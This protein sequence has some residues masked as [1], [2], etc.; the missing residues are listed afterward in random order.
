MTLYCKQITYDEILPYWDILWR[1]RERMIQYSAMRM[2]GGYD[3]DIKNTYKWRAFAVCDDKRGGK[4]V[5]VNAGHKS[6]AR[7]Y[8]TRGLWVSSEYRGRG[9]AQQLFKQLEDQAKHE[10]CRWL[11]S[12]PRLA[13][14]PAYCKAGYE[15]FGE[16]DLG[17]F[18]HCIR[19][20]KDLSVLTTTVWN[21]FENPLEDLQWLD[22]VDLLDK[23]GILLGQNEEVRGNFVHITQHWINDLWMQ[24]ESGVGEHY[25]LHIHKGNPDNPIHVL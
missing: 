4:I 9:I 14:L 19:A 11:W 24:P 25:P 21:I 12:Y 13:A 2:M 3:S 1:D 17:E 8:R 6:G 23:Q 22:Q 5:G 18:D 7:E 15:P 16:A 10:M 20:K